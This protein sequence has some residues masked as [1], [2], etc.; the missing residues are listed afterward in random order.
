MVA[1]LLQRWDPLLRQLNLRRV[2]RRHQRR[3]REH[4]HRA[5]AK[6]RSA[7]RGPLTALASP[8]RRAPT[9]GPRRQPGRVRRRRP[10][11]AAAG[12]G[13]GVVRG[14]APCSSDVQGRR[15]GREALPCR[16]RSRDDVGWGRGTS[17]HRRPRI[18]GRQRRE[19]GRYQE[20]RYRGRRR[21]R[22]ERR[23]LFATDRVGGTRRLPAGPRRQPPKVQVRRRDGGNKRARRRDDR[24]P[25]GGGDTAGPASGGSSSARKAGHGGGTARAAAGPVEPAGRESGPAAVSGARGKGIGGI[26]VAGRRGGSRNASKFP[27]DVTAKVKACLAKCVVFR[28][29]VRRITC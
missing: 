6:T 29:S 3:L 16:S 12:R 11:A 5:G 23:H 1:V 2:D 26:G 18:R 14:G 25:D 20:Q 15:R 9:L 4:A 10:A 7:C 28:S 19:R 13:C 17:P 21:R 8:P 24:R 22:R 27:D